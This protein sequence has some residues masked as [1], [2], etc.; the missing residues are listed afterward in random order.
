MAYILCKRLIEMGRTAG[1]ADK[2]DVYYA[3]G[4]LTS[5]QFLELIGLLREVGDET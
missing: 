2:I 1:L 4:R 3:A 5:E